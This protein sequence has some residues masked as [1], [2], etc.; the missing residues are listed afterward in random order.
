VGRSEGSGAVCLDKAAH[1]VKERGVDIALPF[2]IAARRFRPGGF[3]GRR[4]AQRTVDLVVDVAGLATI[5]LS[6]PKNRDLI[7]GRETEDNAPVASHALQVRA[8]EVIDARSGEPVVAGLAA[9]I[10]EIGLK[11]S[12]TLLYIGA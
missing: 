10:S 4:Q 3:R 11:Q 6:D 9:S 8:A 5:V 12:D 1:I 2:L 7:R